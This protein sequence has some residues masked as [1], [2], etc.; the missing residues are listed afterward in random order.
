VCQ[1]LYGDT[2]RYRLYHGESLSGEE[3]LAKTKQ[4]FGISIAHPIEFVLLKRRSWVEA[5]KY[6]VVTM[7]GQALGSVVLGFDTLLATVE[8]IPPYIFD[9]MGFAFAYPVFVWFGGCK[10]LSYTHYPVISM[11]MLEKVRLV[12]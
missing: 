7:L 10:V 6:P 1:N 4:R 3:I 11:D 9:S 8:D 2:M 12:Y 5:S